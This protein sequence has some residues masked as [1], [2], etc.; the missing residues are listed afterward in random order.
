MCY[1]WHE[2]PESSFPRASVRNSRV[3]RPALNLFPFP[4]QSR[5]SSHRQA[6]AEPGTA[7]LP[8]LSDLQAGARSSQ[9]S[10]APLSLYTQSIIITNTHLTRDRGESGVREHSVMSSDQIIKRNLNDRV[11]LLDWQ[12]KFISRSFK[13]PNSKISIC[14]QEATI[15]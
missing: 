13:F 2:F 8:W 9:L 7:P 15:F 3:P 5:V 12:L 11:I 1:I 6:S 10:P 14:K 4:V